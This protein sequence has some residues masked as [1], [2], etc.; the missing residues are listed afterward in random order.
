VITL[1]GDRHAGRVGASVL[2]HLGRPEWIASDVQSYAALA[3]RLAS[4]RSALARER[5]DLR[6]ALAASS[7][8]DG[9]GF[10]R[11]IERLYRDWVSEAASPK[12]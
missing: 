6:G 9:R 5:R 1:K 7:L 12:T 11:R 10:A 3:L 2:G 4:D 8:M